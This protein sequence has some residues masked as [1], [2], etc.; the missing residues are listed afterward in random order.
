MGGA[1]PGRVDGSG[2]ALKA[3]QGSDKSHPLNS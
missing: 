3:T 2:E 1:A